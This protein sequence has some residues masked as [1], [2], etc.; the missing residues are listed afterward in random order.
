M[1]QY[2]LVCSRSKPTLK[3]LLCQTEKQAIRFQTN[4]IGLTPK[5]NLPRSSVYFASWEAKKNPRLLSV[6]RAASGPT[7]I[8]GRWNNWYYY[9][10][11]TLIRPKLARIHL[12]LRVWQEPPIAVVPIEV[13]D[14]K[15]LLNPPTLERPKRKRRS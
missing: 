4:L 9:G 5:R 6:I 13:L 10:S 11:H 15:L 3:P 12:L 8:Q 1:S 14:E 7:T 2:Y